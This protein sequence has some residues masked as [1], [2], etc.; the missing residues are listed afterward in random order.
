[1]YLVSPDDVDEEEIDPMDLASLESSS[2]PIVKVTAEAEEEAKDASEDEIIPLLESDHSTE[3]EGEIEASETIGTVAL[4]QLED[5][6]GQLDV[7]GNFRNED[8]LQP[9]ED[10]GPLSRAS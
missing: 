6:V 4:D 3:D 10:P 1:M 2:A 9:P 5:G 7:N 8:S